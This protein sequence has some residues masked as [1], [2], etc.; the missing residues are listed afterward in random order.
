MSKTESKAGKRSHNAL[1]RWS[2]SKHK[3]APF[4]W[5]K[6]ESGHDYAVRVPHHTLWNPELAG[7]QGEGEWK[8]PNNLWEPFDTLN[9]DWLT[10]MAHYAVERGLKLTR[11]QISDTVYEYSVVDEYGTIAFSVESGRNIVVDSG[12][13]RRKKRRK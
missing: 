13:S 7:Y 3:G 12:R 8:L 10:E 9:L 11:E 1:T 6:D 4:Y 2:N 5:Y